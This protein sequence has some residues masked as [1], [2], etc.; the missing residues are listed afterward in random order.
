MLSSSR[1]ASINKHA[2]ALLF[3]GLGGRQMQAEMD[4]AIAMNTL[5]QPCRC[6]HFNDLQ[7]VLASWPTELATIVLLNLQ[8]AD[9]SYRTDE[10]LQLLGRLQQCA[11][12][13][14]SIL[15]GPANDKPDRLDDCIGQALALGAFDI[16]HAPCSAA[17]LQQSLCRA[18]L[19]LLQEMQQLTRGEARLNITVTLSEGLRQAAATTEE[20][21]LRRTLCTCNHNVSETARR[22]GLEREQVYYYLKKYGIQRPVP[23]R[24]ADADRTRMTG[25]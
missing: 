9:Q 24:S 21:L 11:F 22:L 4:A 5:Q 7:P 23:P 14:K 6:M 18:R 2:L 16:L 19:F 1:S 8:P 12:L 10:A 13:H 15:L 20:I 3:I 17:L 25:V